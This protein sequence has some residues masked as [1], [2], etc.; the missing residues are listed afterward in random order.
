M[1]WR[2][3]RHLFAYGTLMC[4]DIMA[5]V[6]G[7]HLSPVPATLRGYRR[8]RVKGEHYP[9]LV[10]DAEG[11]VEGVVYRNVPQSA[12]ARLDR[13]EGEM[14]SRKIVQVALTDETAVTAATYV[15]RADFMD[16]L[17]EAEWDFAVFLRKGKG[18][19]CKSYNG[20]QA[21]T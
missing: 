3:M 1:G 14:Y 12:W 4:D 9:A 15:V 20:Y 17:D 10:P 18:P 16:C 6:S 8:R 21:L 13:F 2:R 5:E 11:Y 7:G 19:F